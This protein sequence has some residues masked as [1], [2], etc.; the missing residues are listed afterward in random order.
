M[1]NNPKTPIQ[2]TYKWYVKHYYKDQIVTDLTI[3]LL[4]VLPSSNDF[5]FDRQFSL[6][7]KL[8]RKELNADKI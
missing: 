5:G 3:T 1:S 8:F 6:C 2:V 7:Q 4:I